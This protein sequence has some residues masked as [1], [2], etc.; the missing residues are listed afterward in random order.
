[1]ANANQTTQ[2][3]PSQHGASTQAPAQ[4]TQSQQAP[5]QP[6]G[7]SVIRDYASI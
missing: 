1:M 5:A 2:T 3:T 7:G 4:S 6:T